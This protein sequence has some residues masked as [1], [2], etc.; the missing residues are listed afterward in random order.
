VSP[1]VL[2]AV[3]HPAA[4]A[5]LRYPEQ[6]IVGVG[7]EGAICWIHPEAVHMTEHRR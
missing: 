7:I 3:H 5:I 4:A 2:D 1:I 6:A